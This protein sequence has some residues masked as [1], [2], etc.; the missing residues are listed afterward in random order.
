MVGWLENRL[1][2]STMP[3]GRMVGEEVAC[4]DQPSRMAAWL[5]NRLLSGVASTVREQVVMF[6]HSWYMMA[7]EQVVLIPKKSVL[8]NQAGNLVS[9]LLALATGK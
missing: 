7:G 6:E 4:F 2:R 1:L 3:H 5:E 8:S 9:G